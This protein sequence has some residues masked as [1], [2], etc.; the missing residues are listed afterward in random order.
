MSIRGVSMRLDIVSNTTLNPREDQVLT[1]RY[2][3][4][5]EYTLIDCNTDIVTLGIAVNVLHQMYNEALDRLDNPVLAANIIET[6]EREVRRCERNRN[7]NPK[8]R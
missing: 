7:K 3:P 8:S 4:E 1:V 2:C 6:I 5:R